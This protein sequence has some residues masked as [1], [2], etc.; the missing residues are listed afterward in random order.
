MANDR[1]CEVPPELEELQASIE[2]L[3]E[4]EEFSE[5]R[6]NIEGLR[7]GLS[8]L[9]DMVELPADFPNIRGLRVDI[10]ELVAGEDS[11]E[12]VL[13]ELRAEDFPDGGFPG[14]R[15]PGDRDGEGFPGDL[16]GEGFPDLSIP[17]LSIPDSSIPDSSIPDLSIPDSSI[18]DL[19]I[20]ELL[21]GIEFPDDL[22]N[23]GIGEIRSIGGDRF[24]GGTIGELPGDGEGPADTEQLRAR[25]EEP[26]ASGDFDGLRG[27]IGRF[28]GGDRFFN[29]DMGIGIGDDPVVDTGALFPDPV[30]D[31]SSVV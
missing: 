1:T 13:D 12:G 3:H 7:D 9:R 27:G 22:L 4:S 29:R 2:A 10:S 6:A 14:G 30:V 5:V 31:G 25:I 23:G 18:P 20:P 11:L 19:S 8:E 26:I 15:F 24:G 21:E 17:D 28:G 16:D